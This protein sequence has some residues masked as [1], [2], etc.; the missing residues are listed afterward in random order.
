MKAAQIKSYSKEINL[1]ICNIPIPSISDDEVLVKVKAAAVN[2]LELLILTGSVRLIQDYKMPLTLG[3]EFSVIVEETGKNV[4]DFKIGDK[5]YARLPIYKIGAFAEYVS[6]ESKFLSIMPN[7]CSFE[8]AAAIPLTALTAYQAFTE[9]LEA[10]SGQTVLITG[11][12][13]SFGELAVPI[14][15]HL[16]LNIIVSGN[17]RSKDHFINLGVSKYIDYSKENYWELVSAADY[18][19]DTLGAKEFDRE[20]SVLK[21]G[22][23]LL[24]LRTSPNKRF[25]EDN[26]FS[27]LKKLLFSAAGSKYD[28]KAM[29]EGKE[30]RFMFVRADGEELRKITKITEEQNIK[31]KIFSTVFNLENANEAVKTMAKGH[32]E[33]KIII[34]L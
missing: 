16:G 8:T 22:G 24:S 27:F 1:N 2:P 20:L 30:Y 26:K 31:P 25:A 18:V 4:T 32:I 7:N 33:G 19:I 28:K 10:K 34:S 9:E 6:I 15:K 17:E 14:A 3:N 21:K 11:G 23:R 12:S 29:K 5:V 13:G